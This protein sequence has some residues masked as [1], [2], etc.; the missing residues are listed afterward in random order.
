MA[1]IRQM[2][3]KWQVLIRKKFA[4]HLTKTFVYKHDAEKY[5]REKEAE[6]DKGLVINY[7]EAA[8]TTL[9]EL[10]ERYRVQITSKKKSPHSEDCKIKYLTRL[11]IAQLPIMKIS[12]LKISK[13]RDELLLD[14][15]PATVMHYLS[16]IS[17]AWNIAQKEWNMNLPQN[18]VSQISKPIIR[19]RRD[20][21]LTKSEYDRLLKATENSTFY[22]KNMF[23]FAYETAAR[24]G[25]V[26][27]LNKSDV[28]FLK[29]TCKFR[30]TK[31]GEDRDCPLTEAAI[32]A[33]K[34]QPPSMNGNYFNVGTDDKFK[35]YWQKVKIAA[36]VENFRWHDLRACAITNFMLPPFNFTI[37]QTAVISGHK[38]WD[39]LKRYERIK[40]SQI[41]DQFKKLKR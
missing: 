35:Y 23:I 11:D 1:T 18:P 19:D 38:S 33:L 10:L 15:K 31:N 20:R 6:I 8:R 3:G 9:G 17:S 34:S 22:M 25:E 2:K 37:A 32:K 27:R 36:E 39:E 29:R 24:Y 14:R 40:A 26:I 13:L 4:K 30:D 16:Y 41:V 28:N 7:E 21:I 12:T 5:A